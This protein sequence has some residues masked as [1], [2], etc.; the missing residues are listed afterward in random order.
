MT[1]LLRAAACSFSDGGK[2][3]RETELVFEFNFESFMAVV[4]AKEAISFLDGV[5]VPGDG[6]IGHCCI[7]ECGVVGIP[8]RFGSG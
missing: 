4:A 7:G 6:G 1:V 3:E 2:W 5:V 8:Y